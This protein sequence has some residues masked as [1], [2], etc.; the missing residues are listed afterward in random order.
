MIKLIESG[1][2]TGKTTYVV[3]EVV[4]LIKENE[5]KSS[6]FLLL[7]FTNKAA[8]EMKDRV[9]IKL[10]EEF[11]EDFLFQGNAST[12][13]SFAKKMIERYRHK[14]FLSE[15]KNVKWM[16]EKQIYGLLRNFILPKYIAIEPVESKNRQKITEILKNI[17][18]VKQGLVELSSFNQIFYNI[19][20]DYHDFLNTYKR[21]DYSDGLILLDDLLD[22][23]EVLQDISNSY[24]YVI[25]DEFQDCNELQFRI[26]EKLSKIN[27]NL[28][29]VG[30]K[31]QSIYA[32]NGGQ[33]KFIENFK[34]YFPNGIV[35]KLEKNYRSTENII[36]TANKVI[37]SNLTTVHEKGKEVEFV[38]IGG[39]SEQFDFI[40]NK[41]LR[42]KEEYKKY[43]VLARSNFELLGVAKKLEEKNIPYVIKKDNELDDFINETYILFLKMIYN[44][45]NKDDLLAL[46]EKFPTAYNDKVMLN[47]INSLDGGNL[48]NLINVSY[49]HTTDKKM[50]AIYN[51]IIEKRKEKIVLNR[52]TIRE[53]I[54]EIADFCD[55]INSDTKKYF[56]EGNELTKFIDS[57]STLNFIKFLENFKGY[58]ENFNK[59]LLNL[60]KALLKNED[61]A[62]KLM[63][64]HSAKGLEF[65]TVFLIN[66]FNGFFPIVELKGE[67][68]YLK[69]PKNKIEK[70]EE[71]I[72]LYGEEKR[73]AYVGLTRAKKELILLF[74]KYMKGKKNYKSYFFESFNFKKS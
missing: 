48:E 24:K 3:N 19:W 56:I 22:D 14:T 39:M 52:L 58:E 53:L 2:G 26:V 27:Q 13:H 65:E 51:F 41:I 6:E 35:E 47:I 69:V 44:K 31:N 7:T 16:H 64:I 59:F 46:I 30:D 42:E 5:V 32:F 38:E 63:T 74:P 37:G 34:T 71:E 50:L 9:E 57:D 67:E 29:L 15:Y 55:F 23:K 60:Q 36:E 70:K 20:T 43:C 61:N 33:V 12:F 73:I 11:D 25:V 17:S 4:R 1:A 54:L 68:T 72:K 21:I 28:L 10:K 62:V 45:Y 40:S 66:C 49:N 8:K 18:S